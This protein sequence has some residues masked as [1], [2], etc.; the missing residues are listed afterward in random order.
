MSTSTLI[1]RDSLNLA[2]GIKGFSFI[3]LY[4]V[5]NLFCQL[6]TNKQTIGNWTNTSGSIDLDI[7]PHLF[8]RIISTSESKNICMWII[9]YYNVHWPFAKN[10]YQFNF[11]VGGAFASN[12]LVRLIVSRVGWTVGIFIILIAASSLW[13]KE[14]NIYFWNKHNCWFARHYIERE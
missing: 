5:I 1:N 2:T 10:L 11:L 9:F 6:Q 12:W 3:Q 7:N 13:F 14:K 8:P 4:R